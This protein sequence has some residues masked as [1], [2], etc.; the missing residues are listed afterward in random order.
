M[1]GEPLSSLLFSPPL[2]I[3]RQSLEHSQGS[4]HRLTAKPQREGE[5]GRE[6]GR[7]R[8]EREGMGQEVETEE[9]WMWVGTLGIKRRGSEIGFYLF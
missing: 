7:E 1:S 5:R 6:R 4:I 2:S 9:K 3:R 8:E